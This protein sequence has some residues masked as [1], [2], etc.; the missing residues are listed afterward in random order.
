MTESRALRKFEP[1]DLSAMHRIREAAFRPVFRS[2]RDTVGEQIAPIVL[3]DAEAEQARFLDS[4]CAP[5]ADHEIHVVEAEGGIVGF[6]SVSLNHTKKVGEIDLIAAHPDHQGSGLGTWMCEQA[7][8]RM[9]EAGMVAA[10][11]GTGGD[12]GHAPARRAYEKVGF[13]NSLPTLHYYRTL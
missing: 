3:V 1:D 13:A 6:F 9:K 5:G 7:L 4:I 12:P 8:D 2:L 10:Y 11:V